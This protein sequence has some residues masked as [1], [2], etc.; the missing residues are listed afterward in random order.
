MVNV[1]HRSLRFFGKLECCA[2]L[3]CIFSERRK[4][5]CEAEKAHLDS[6]SIIVKCVVQ[7]DES[8]KVTH[9]RK[10]ALANMVSTKISLLSIK[11]DSSKGDG[12]VT[13]R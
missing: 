2:S 6:E 4:D 9:G 3:T 1:I 10:H 11:Y 13:G 12:A 5:R 7:V 8:Q